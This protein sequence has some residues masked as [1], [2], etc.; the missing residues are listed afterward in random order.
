MVNCAF[1]F[2][3]SE[4]EKYFERI[5][6]NL[7]CPSLSLFFAQPFKPQYWSTYKFSRLI[8]IYF[9][10]WKHYMIAWISSDYLESLLLPCWEEK[11]TRSNRMNFRLHHLTWQ[12]NNKRPFAFVFP[13][14]RNVSHESQ[15]QQI[16]KAKVNDMKY[17]APFEKP[18]REIVVA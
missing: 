14:P 15:L 18:K 5:I 16:L 6:M 3:Q 10:I 11:T 17:Y 12:C 13:W 9:F 1:A 2:S 4:T 8:F 7:L